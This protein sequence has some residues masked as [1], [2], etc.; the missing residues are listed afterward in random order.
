MT[1]RTLLQS[2]QN[3]GG[4]FDIVNFDDHPGSVF[5]VGSGVTGA[6]DAAGYGDSPDAPFATLDY[7]I[8]QCTANKGDVIYV[9]PGHAETTTA[10]ALDVAGVKIKGLGYGRSRPSLTATTAATD[11]LNVTAA[12][13]VLE[14]VRLIGAAS[15]VTALLD[16]SAAAT[17]FVARK[18]SFEH[19]A[20]PLDAIT[21]SGDR[22]LFED[23][24]WLGTANGPDYCV[25]LEAKCNDWQIIR[26]RAIYKA[27]LDNAF[28][29]AADKS[30]LGYIIDDLFDFLL[31]PP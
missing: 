5:F 15:G 12:N 6:T 28:I 2:R 4:L 14:N 21:W 7:A 30:Q 8:G 31:D 18:V 11:L 20:A 25:T 24:T 19:G 3:P 22:F 17:D 16:G 10:I 1:N 29:R 26:P 27:G 13:C 23:C 9:L